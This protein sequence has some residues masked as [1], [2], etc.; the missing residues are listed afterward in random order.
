MAKL[1]RY[2]VLFIHLLLILGVVLSLLP[3]FWMVS[4]SFKSA[5]KAMALPPQWIPNPFYWKTYMN[6]WRAAP[7]ARLFLN[8]I[9]MAVSVTLGHLAFGSLAAFAFA[10]IKVPGGKFLFLFYLATMMIPTQVLLIPQYLVVHRFGW[11][12]T[13][14]ALIIPT[15]AGAFSTFL[16]R[17]FFLTLPSELEDAALIDGCSWYRIFWQI[18]LPLS[19]PALASVTII[20]FTQ[21][22]NSFL[23]PLVVTNRMKMRNVQ[24]GLSIF[25]EEFATYW[26]EL[27][28]ACTFITIPTLIVFLVF[29]KYFVT[30][31]ATT[32]LKE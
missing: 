21:N 31:I 8:S 19:K 15:M 16:L 22:W 20:I 10:R 26:P 18:I 29:Q 32:G 2:L 5:S 14:Y 7:F 28:A 1:Q 24:V 4:T 6:A 25:R 11:I 27:M 9:F 3:F 13:Y 17:Q 12:D 30:G 23:W